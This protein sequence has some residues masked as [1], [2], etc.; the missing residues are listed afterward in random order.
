MSK[1][2]VRCMLYFIL[3]ICG[4]RGRTHVQY[5][6]IEIVCKGKIQLVVSFLE[7]SCANRELNVRHDWLCTRDQD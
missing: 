7:Y 3:V 1:E 4:D 2:F 6:S 5:L